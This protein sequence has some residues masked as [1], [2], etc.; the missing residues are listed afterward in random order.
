MRRNTLIPQFKLRSILDHF[1]QFQFIPV[2][3]QFGSLYKQNK[4]KTMLF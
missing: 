2:K 3:F 1:G 4:H